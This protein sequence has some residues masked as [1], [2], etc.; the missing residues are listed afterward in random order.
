MNS[1]RLLAAF[2]LTPIVP[3]ILL[4]VS[5]ASSPGGDFN[6]PSHALKLTYQAPGTGQNGGYTLSSHGKN[7]A[8]A[9]T[10]IPAEAAQSGDLSGN[11]SVLWSPTEKTALIFEDISDTSPDYRYYLLRESGD[12]DGWKV[13]Q[14]DFGSWKSADSGVSNQIFSSTHRIPAAKW[15]DDE[16]AGISWDPKA[17]AEK[18]KWSEARLKT[19]NGQ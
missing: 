12:G 14:V 1:S 8:H 4:A 19:L 7:L 5:C 10:V 2:R 3:A 6:S 11:H 15:I 16:G 18:M 9:P 13:S 17:P